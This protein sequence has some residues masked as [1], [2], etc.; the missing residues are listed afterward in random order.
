MKNPLYAVIMNV[1]AEVNPNELLEVYKDMEK[2]KLNESN[3]EFLLDMMKKLNRDKKLKEEGIKEGREE[4]IRQ[5]ILK[6][7]H[8]GL[9]IEYIADINDIKIE[10]V[11]KIV[12][13]ASSTAQS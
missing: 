8:K 6:Q 11:K 3:R 4:G 2:A 10:Y 1:L 7:Y 5:L 13:D 12:S 9:S